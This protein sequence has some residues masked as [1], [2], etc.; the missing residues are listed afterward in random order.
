[1][2]DTSQEEVVAPETNEEVV[3]SSAEVDTVAIT[4]KDYD[5]LNQ[6]LGS[7]KREIKDL[8]KPKEE[9]ETSK[10]STSEENIL[11]QKLEKMSLRQAG[12]EH[13]DDIELARN[14]AKKWNMDIDDVLADPDFKT[15]L[16][17][18]QTT[19]ANTVASSNIRGSQGQ[20]GTVAKL[21]KEFWI[22]KGQLP[23]PADIPDATVRRKIAYE[24]MKSVQ[25]GSGG[26]KFYNS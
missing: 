6:T 8:K 22:A 21:T 13:A 23:T 25:G 17:R 3:E 5:L 9:K 2:T 20:G 26:K 19:R 24:V 15:K 11:L 18:Q 1:M 10:K 16:E 7:L 14:T 12:I 4:K